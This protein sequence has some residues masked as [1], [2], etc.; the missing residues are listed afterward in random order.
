MADTKSRVWTNESLAASS[1]DPEAA[2][3]PAPARRGPRRSFDLPRVVDAALAVVDEGGPDALSIRA[4]AGRLGVN[5]NAVY[6]YVASRAALEREIV[7]RVLAGSDLALLEKP[8]GSRRQG[9]VAY[10][11]S[12]RDTLLTHPAVARLM[13]T[14]PM[15]GPTALL[16]GE[17]LI[18]ALTV[19]GLSLDDAARATYALIVQV[20]G[21]VALEVAET[22]GT[23]PLAPEAERVAGRRAA[24]GFL[25]A[26]QWPMTAATRDVAAEWISKDQFVW[27][28]ERLLDG[29]LPA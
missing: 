10:S 14:A 18:D 28:V 4:V 26:A 13:M 16:V 25:D 12:L 3:G 19:A 9:I 21:A 6:T 8:T 22:D 17:R 23:P 11:V 27:S 24:L 2:E 15:D 29:I 20:L 7:E 5:P 1:A